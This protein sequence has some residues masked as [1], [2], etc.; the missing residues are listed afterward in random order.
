MTKKNDVETVSITANDVETPKR[1][2]FFARREK[3]E[4]GERTSHHNE[5]SKGTKKSMVTRLPTAEAI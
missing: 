5:L 2:G 1:K 4:K 3:G